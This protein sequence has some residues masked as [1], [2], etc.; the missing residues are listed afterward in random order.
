M[1][2]QDQQ[3]LELSGVTPEPSL[4]SFIPPAALQGRDTSSPSAY[5]TT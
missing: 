2:L 1:K 3:A 4:S 5:P